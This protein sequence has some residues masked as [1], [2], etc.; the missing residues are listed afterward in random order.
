M[1]TQYKL[2]RISPEN[3]SALVAEGLRGVLAPMM[4]HLHAGRDRRTV[5][6][7]SL[8]DPHG[9]FVSSTV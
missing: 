4:N 5:K 3:A 6:G 8:F 7:Y 9:N 2:Y 1:N